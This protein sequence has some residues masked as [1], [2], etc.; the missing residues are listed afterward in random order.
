MIYN[1]IALGYIFSLFF[2]ACKPKNSEVN[3]PVSI[4]K[5]A[6]SDS[7]RQKKVMQSDTF[8]HQTKQEEEIYRIIESIPEVKGFSKR[9]ELKQQN[10]KL[11][12]I[13]NQ[14]P[15]K[16]FNYYWVQVGSSDQYRYQPV[17][18]FYINNKNFQ[19]NYYD[20]STDS[21]ITLKKWRQTR[22]W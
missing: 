11:S 10:K 1:I 12:I 8:F 22:G 5:N 4:Q 6:S 19:I 21:I 14:R 15:S 18:N 7:L 13:I 20:T 9:Y 17:Y 2:I 3:H 16:T